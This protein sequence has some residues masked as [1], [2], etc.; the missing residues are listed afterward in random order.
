MRL[1]TWFNGVCIIV[2]HLFG[3]KSVH[4][5]FWLA[6]RI[7]ISYSKF[8]TF[9]YL[10]ISLHIQGI[11]EAYRFFSIISVYWITVRILF[12][13]WTFLIFQLYSKAFRILFCIDATGIFC[14]GMRFSNGMIPGLVFVSDS[15][16]PVTC[17]HYHV[18]ILAERSWF[19]CP[20]SHLTVLDYSLIR[21]VFSDRWV[22]IPF[23]SVVNKRS[24]GL[25]QRRRNK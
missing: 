20:K 5:W 4:P 24:Q 16:V 22:R 12:R 13:I 2:S 18:E 21:E 25:S 17:N 8:G 23:H 7:L 6:F 9:W 19:S 11:I 14:F 1:C 3:S 15:S 10:H